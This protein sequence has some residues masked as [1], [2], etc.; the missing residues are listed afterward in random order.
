MTLAVLDD[1][2]LDAVTG[3]TFLNLQNLIT[4]TTQTNVG[5]NISTFSFKSAQTNVQGNWNW[6]SV[7]N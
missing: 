6:S 7:S 4:N 2:E 3:G 1:A 5:V